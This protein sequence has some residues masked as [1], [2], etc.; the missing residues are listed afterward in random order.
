[1]HDLN[2]PQTGHLH[3]PGKR[4]SSS[5]KARIIMGILAGI[6]VVGLGM[7]AFLLFKP[8][9]KEASPAP[10]QSEQQQSPEETQPAMDPAQ[11][12]QLTAYKSEKLAIEVTHRKDWSVRESADG[13]QLILASP[14]FAYE[15]VEG[16]TTTGAF[17]LKIGLGASDAAQKTLNTSKTVKDS[18][19]IGYDAPTEQ[20]RHYTHLSFAGPNETAFAYFIVTGSIALK[21]STALSNTI[22]INDGDFLIV[23]GF[24]AD[25]ENTLDYS[26]LDPANLEQYAPYEQAIAIVKS[27][28]V[29]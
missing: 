1:M 4:A 5:K 20:Q 3:T 13:K 22:I 24:G 15:T 10:A 19:L 26:K 25:T 2:Q 17:T 11:A 8:D 16:E 12:S 23:G 21:A 14:K 28:K 7:G 6:V 29:Y 27:L 9:T 18:L